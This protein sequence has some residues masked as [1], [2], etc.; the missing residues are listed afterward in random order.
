M[1]VIFAAFFGFL[2]F[3][4]PVQA[5]SASDARALA[6]AMERVRADQWGALPRLSNA[7]AAAVVEWHRL[8]AGEGR[9]KDYLS[10]LRNYGDWPGLPLMFKRGEK[11]ISENART[12]DVLAY[13]A[14]HGAQTALGAL[15]HARA[16]AQSGRRDAARDEIRNAWLN[17][18]MTTAEE[19]IYRASW[20]AVIK[21]LNSE[22]LDMLLWRQRFREA[23]RLFPRV[24][25]GEV[26]V[27]RARIGLVRQVDGVDGLVAAVPASLKNTPGLAYERF[28]WRDRKG[29]EDSAADLAIAQSGT[30]KLGRPEEWGNRR[31]QIARRLMREGK[32][33]KAYA[34]ASAH[35]LTSG[36]H[37]ADLEWLS[38]YLALRKLKRPGDALVHFKNH[39]NATVSPISRGRAGY[40]IGRA[41]EAMD[42]QAEA[43]AAYAEG[44]GYQTSFYGQLA[45]EKIGAAS[46]PDLMGRKTYPGW[47]NA[48]FTQSSVYRAGRL[49]LAAGEL[50]LA[51]RWFVHLSERLSPAEMGQLA[52]MALDNGEAHLALRIAKY[53]ASQG[54]VLHAAYFPVPKLANVNLPVSRR[55]AL[56]I[57]RR[58]SEFDIKVVSPA[59]ARGLM[60]LMPGTAK[61]MARK[62]GMEYSSRR[63]LT[64]GGYNA[65]L[66]AAYLAQLIEEFGANIPLISAGYNAGPGRPRRWIGQ[67][68]DPRSSR[69]DVVDWI[70]HVPFRETRNYVMRVFESVIVYD[71]RLK[72]RIVP[73][74]PTPLLKAR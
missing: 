65:T 22:R 36:R 5:Q 9:M 46:N 21:G 68:G 25:K 33:S 44:A 30:G 71:M 41:Y 32:S 27:A 49:L 53:A 48:G 69:T 17:Y 74:K 15:H 45:A 57:A 29:Y 43:R 38:G 4:S 66:G 61:A 10:F 6:A 8:R 67:Y 58:E 19:A 56:S 35:G 64:D 47:Q 24:S 42:M 72:G 1:R 40:W 14:P 60:Q 34:L 62:S 28:V 18:P 52:Q 3:V 63:L 16:L 51:E 2:L 55:L 70:E 73:L 11:R 20:G 26:A 50:D 37:Y 31:R 54:H 13:F 59:G 12:A 7:D 23:E 39:R